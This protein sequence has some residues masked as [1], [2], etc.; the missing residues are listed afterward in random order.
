MKRISNTE[1]KR[2]KKKGERRCRKERCCNDKPLVSQF[3]KRGAHMESLHGG[4]AVVA[5]RWVL[6]GRRTSS[7]R[8][9]QHRFYGASGEG[10]AE[11][12]TRLLLLIYQFHVYHL[13]CATTYR[14]NRTKANTETA[15]NEWY[16]KGKEKDLESREGSS[17]RYL[18]SRSSTGSFL[19]FLRFLLER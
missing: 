1:R 9:R 10:P 7:Y 12:R 16:Q 3:Y 14:R 2:G 8:G 18:A 6:C 13:P 15:K 17:F 4:H 11:R 5:A 19:L